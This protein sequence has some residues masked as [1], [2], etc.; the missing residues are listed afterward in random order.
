MY[1]TAGFVIASTA[2]EYT[3]ICSQPLPVTV[4]TVPA[5]AACRP[6]TR[7]SG[8]PMQRPRWSR[9][10]LVLAQPRAAAHVGEHQAEEGQRCGDVDDVQHGAPRNQTCRICGPGRKNGV[11]EWDTA[12][13]GASL[14]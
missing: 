5:A 14:I 1:T 6:D 13:R 12:T 3:R 7:G 2:A 4:R 11:K 8:R 10:S 9:R